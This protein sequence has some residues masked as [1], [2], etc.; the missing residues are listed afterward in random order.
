MT[1]LYLVYTMPNCPDCKNA[2]ELLERE[3]VAFREVKKFTPQELIEKVGPVRSLPQI[4][5]DNASGQYHIGGF[6]DL[7]AFVRD[8][9]PVDVAR[10]IA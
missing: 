4:I 1:A 5:L 10:K 7:V 8:G 6:K 9:Y 3:G 2:K